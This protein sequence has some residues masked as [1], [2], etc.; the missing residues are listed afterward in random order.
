MKKSAAI[1][2]VLA[3]CS[4]PVLAQTVGFSGPNAP[5]QA[6]VIQQSGGF[7]GGQQV[8]TTVAKAKDL[9]DDS[10][11]VLQGNIEQR[12][13]GE[14]YIFR[15]ATGSMEVEIDHKYWNGQTVTPKDKV[16]IQGKIDKDWNSINVD[17]KS[18]RKMN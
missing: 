6:Q 9:R 2:A 13:R 7:V 1:L 12:V 3:L 14:H 8:V 5:Q 18:L 11:V 4:A 17:V 10:W 15:D 16:E